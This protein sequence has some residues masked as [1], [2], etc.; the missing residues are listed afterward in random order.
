MSV[1]TSNKRIEYTLYSDDAGFNGQFPGQLSRY[2][3]MKPSWVLL[4]HDIMN[5]VGD[6]Q[7]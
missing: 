3:N 7:K 5:D 4:L 6:N 2:Q 1:V